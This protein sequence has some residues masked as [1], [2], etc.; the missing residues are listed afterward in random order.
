MHRVLIEQPHISSYSFFLLL[1]FL[2]GFLLARWNAKRVGIAGRHVDN[3]TLLLVLTG[4][5]GARVFSWLFD[6][7]AGIGFWRGLFYPGGGLVFY[8]G[9]VF[10]IA[11]VAFYALLTRISLRKFADLLAP[12]LAVGLAFGRIGCFMAGCCWGDLCVDGKSTTDL[13]ESQRA[14]V[15]TVAVISRQGFPLAVRFPADTGA[16]RQHHRLGLV[17]H[18]AEQSLPVHPV[19]LYEAVL[20]F[21]L[22]GWLQWRRSRAYPPGRIMCLFCV[23]YG[24]IRFLLEFL[25]ADNSASYWG[26]TISQVISAVAVAACLPL[27]LQRRSKQPAPVI[28]EPAV[29]TVRD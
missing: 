4:I 23:G 14:R 15:H 18:D 26:L 3:V 9:V 2:A 12:S 5:A 6:F 10:G 22:A 8:G 13:T 27:L 11:T 24:I 7:P 1:G 16:L 28:S 29:V 25:R 21:G 17:P 20:V 19:Q